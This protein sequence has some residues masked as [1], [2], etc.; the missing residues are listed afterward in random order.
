MR[1]AVMLARDYAAKR[2]AFGR[3]LIDLPLHATTLARLECECQVATHL[4][5][6]VAELLGHEEGGTAAPE[7]LALLRLLTPVV[8][9][10]TAR[11]AIAVASEALEAFGGAGY[12]EDTG[13]PR[14]LRDAQVLSIWEGTTN[15]LSLDVWRAI[16]REG[17][18]ADALGVLRRRAQAEATGAC[19]SMAR[20]IDA[21]LEAIGR[22]AATSTASPERDA[23]ARA[24]AF[25]LARTTAAVLLVEH[26]AWALAHTA[27]PR[28]AIIA[29]R[30]CARGLARFDTADLRGD[31]ELV[32]GEAS[33]PR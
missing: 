9:L 17:V 4:V 5:F 3:A 32:R 24:F 23:N 15:V 2:V 33:T 21:A 22:Y 7:D 19:A 27:D 13:I 10:Y 14:L 25:A 30:W 12:I 18:L 11:Q 20:Q 31:R 26:A 29:A 16:D 8:K 28:P 1:R 6:A